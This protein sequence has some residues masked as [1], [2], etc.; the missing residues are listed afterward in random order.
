MSSVT[1]SDIKTKNL[2]ILRSVYGKVGMKYT[3]SPCP[4]KKTGRYPDCVKRVDSNNDI[5]LKDSERN[6]DK[7]W[8]KESDVFIIE[9][10][11]TFDLDDPIDAA[12]WEAIKNCPIIAPS[13]EAKDDNGVSM[14][15]GDR[16]NSRNP[17]NGIAELYIEK[18]GEDTV[19]K[20]SKK[21]LQHDAVSYIF[22]DD[23]GAEGRVIKARILGKN[24]QNQSDADVT[25]Y[26]LQI[27]EKDPNKIIQLYTGGDLTLKILFIE[28]KDKHVISHKDRVYWYG[29]KILG[30]TDDA[31]ITWMKNTNNKKIVD[32]IKQATYPEMYINEEK[33]NK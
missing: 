32:L 3:I 18:P 1:K 25:D 7:H 20:I 19:R 23:R 15:D 6:S 29:D 24:M 13:R 11:K 28:A 14:I 9:D 2:I 16:K 21:K 10:G 31:V 30:A 5:I 22:D 8:I 27:A 17:R 4:D 12:E 26:L 33:S